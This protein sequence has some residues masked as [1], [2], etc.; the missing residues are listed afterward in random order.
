VVPVA[1]VALLI[2]AVAIDVGYDSVTPLRRGSFFGTGSGGDDLCTPPDE[3]I[4]VHYR[5]TPGSTMLFGGDVRNAGP[6]PITIVGAPADDAGGVAGKRLLFLPDAEATD[7]TTAV[8]FQAFTLP[9]GERR[10]I[11]EERVLQCPP[12]GANGH[13]PVMFDALRLRY[14]LLAVEHE[15]AVPLLGI[16]FL[17]HPDPVACPAP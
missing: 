15:V 12:G 7:L 6:L 10:V 17:D 3:R 14:R 1:V 16:V 11:V 4:C 8:P 5:F 9:P 2:A 13:G